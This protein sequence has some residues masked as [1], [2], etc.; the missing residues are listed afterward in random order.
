MTPVW[1][2]ARLCTLK[3]AREQA[4]SLDAAVLVREQEKKYTVTHMVMDSKREKLQATR[5]Y[6]GKDGLL[7]RCDFY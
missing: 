3:P 1:R 5:N 6:S 4:R 2:L 7:Q